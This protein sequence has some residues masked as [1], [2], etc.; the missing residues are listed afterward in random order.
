MH[1]YWHKTALHV[2]KR[3]GN[4]TD[5]TTDSN[6]F[7]FSLLSPSRS[8]LL[9]FSRLGRFIRALSLQLLLY[10]RSVRIRR[11]AGVSTAKLPLRFKVELGV[12]SSGSSCK[13]G[14]F[15]RWS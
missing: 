10:L 7:I 8:V 2:G 9:L 6:N 5:C 3:C 14:D 4:Y 12:F 13:A 15:G 1:Y 11:C